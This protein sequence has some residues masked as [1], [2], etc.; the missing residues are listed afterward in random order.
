[1]IHEY[2]INGLPVKTGDIIC[3][4]DGG[5]PILEGQFW[6]FVGSLIPGEVDH[7]AVYV[8][9]EGRCI[10]AGPKGVNFYELENNTWD[11]MKL[12][13]QRGPVV[14]V[15]YGVA[16]PVEGRDLTEKQKAEIRE[17]V[18]EYCVQQ[19]GKPY[20]LNFLDAE[21]E[22]TFYCS[23]LV[24]LAYLKNGIN[25]NTNLGVPHFPRMYNII[26]PQEIWSGSVNKRAAQV[27]P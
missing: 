1:M 15:F 5:A 2:V 22:D 12:R 16:L 6:R 24:Y 17:S 3:T 14:D 4:H 9:P 27:S 13:N 8:G 19:A 7:V 26:F 18:A 21:T 10:E 25:L 11:A 20:N 23:Q